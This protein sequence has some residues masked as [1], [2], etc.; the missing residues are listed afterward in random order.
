[1]TTGRG[2]IWANL[3]LGKGFPFRVRSPIATSRSGWENTVGRAIADS[4]LITGQSLNADGRNAGFI[5]DPSSNIFT[6]ATP[7]G[8]TNT[9]TQG[10]NRFGRITGHGV[11]TGIGR[12][13]FVWQQETITKGK[14]E[15]VPFLDRIKIDVYTSTRGINDSGLL[16]GFISDTAG[17]SDG[18]IGSD[19]GGYQRLVAPGGEVPGYSTICQGINNFAQVVCGVQD[20]AGQSVG[21]FIGSPNKGEKD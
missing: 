5:Y 15:L 2:W 17:R 12:Y 9:I 20:S 10:M 14:R 11:E 13:G 16:V 8:S 19:A 7:P 18:F 6:D 21:Q 3:L 1:M 4:G